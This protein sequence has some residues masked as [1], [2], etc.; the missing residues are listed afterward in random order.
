MDT[1][2]PVNYRIDFVGRD[3]SDPSAASPLFFSEVLQSQGNTFG[4]VPEPR[5]VALLAL[6]V[7]TMGAGAWRRRAVRTA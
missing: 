1:V 6:G 2:L 5:S 7:L 4:V 3:P